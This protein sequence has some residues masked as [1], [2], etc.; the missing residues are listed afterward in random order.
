MGLAIERR[1]Y[2]V[3][4]SLIAEPIPRPIPL[5]LY[6]KAV[7]Y[8]RTDA[9][10]ITLYLAVNDGYFGVLTNTYPTRHDIVWLA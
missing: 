6:H 10:V 3:T 1:R 4:S 7:I 8:P 5:I 2:N 9:T